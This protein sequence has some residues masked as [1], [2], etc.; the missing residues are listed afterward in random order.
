MIGI[1]KIL[2]KIN[3]KV[4][5]GESLDIER[6]WDEHKEDLNNN[7]HHSKK[8]QLA[9]NKYGEES[10]EFLI[11]KDLTNDTYINDFLLELVLLKYEDI[12]IHK[13]NSVDEGYNCEYT[14]QKVKN[15]EREL[16]RIKINDKYKLN[17]YITIVEHRFE[18]GGGEFA[19][20]NSQAK[21]MGKNID[22][23]IEYNKY[24]DAIIKNFKFEYRSIE[25]Y[26]GYLSLTEL[27]SKFCIVPDGIY[28]YLESIDVI[29]KN[30]KLKIKSTQIKNIVDNINFSDGTQIKIKTLS[31]TYI[32]YL[33]ICQH[34]INNYKDFVFF[35]INKI[36]K[37]E[38]KLITYKERKS[39]NNFLDIIKYC[40]YK[41]CFK[42]AETTTNAEFT[43]KG[44]INKIKVSSNK[45]AW[46]ELEIKDYNLNKTDTIILKIDEEI[47]QEFL[48]AFRIG[49]RVELYGEVLID[50]M[51]L[52]VY[53]GDSLGENSKEMEYCLEQGLLKKVD[54]E[55]FSFLDENTNKIKLILGNQYDDLF[56]EDDWLDK[57]YKKEVI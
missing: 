17:K 12:Y 10:F 48:K 46:I 13:Y 18:R 44:I 55:H 27:F 32:G 24:C 6:R 35:D 36:K 57:L 41:E 33:M 25:P 26:D 20:T 21:I 30:K 42:I 45:E 56:E 23:H 54:S 43:V 49:D 51:I 29:N 28:E 14:Y 15:G 2:N 5:V 52:E 39:Y 19:P 40:E 22:K 1:Y 9:W 37:K 34:I 50:K 7:K 31:F 3:N 38:N 11:E 8:L 16:N 4:Y 53:G 47:K